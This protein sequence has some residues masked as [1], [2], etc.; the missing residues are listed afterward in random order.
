LRECPNYASSGTAGGSTGKGRYEPSSG[1]N[2][3]TNARNGH[4][5]QTSKEARAHC[6]ANAGPGSGGLS[7]IIF[8]VEITIRISGDLVS[9]EHFSACPTKNSLRVG[10]Q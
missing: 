5:A 2:Y 8:S 3:R 4:D 7:P 10:T 6:C 9:S 1:G